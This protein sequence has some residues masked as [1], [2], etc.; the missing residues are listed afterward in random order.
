MKGKYSEN[1]YYFQ[2][3]DQAY[4][5]FIT[6][7]GGFVYNNFGGSNV[8]YKK[9]HHFD[10]AWLHNLGG[11][12][13]RTSVKKVCSQD[14]NDLIT[15]LEEERGILDRGYSECPCM[16]RNNYRKADFNSILI[17]SKKIYSKK[18]TVIDSSK[19]SNK[20]IDLESAKEF[21]KKLINIYNNRKIPLYVDHFRKAG[22]TNKSLKTDKNKIFQLIILAAYDQQPFT[23]AARGWEP[24][25]FELPEILAK[26]GLYSLKNIKES[27][28]AEVEEKL[29]NTTFYNYHID[30][31]GKLGTSYAETFMDTLNLCENYSILKMI[32]NAS[33]SREVKDIQ[34]LISQKIRNIG[35][36]I[37]SKIIMYTMREIKVGIAQPE[38]FVL[39]V[40]DLL[41][42]YHNNKFAKEIEARYGIGYISE[43]IKNL[44]ELGDPLAIDALYFVDRDEPQL[45]KELL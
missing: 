19:Y 24:I 9:L 14:K 8:L 20:A 1:I 21:A 2:N 23:R 43:S 30:S 37:A 13:L 38:H 12:K 28:I 3:D 33:T 27:K 25:W 35:P 18:N 34:V 36:M 7:N 26:L 10:C 4:I 41:G 6:K 31:K 45:K 17:S 40:E 16:N 29:K 39:I 5:E 44:K 32:L 42:E 22:F 15:W 11:G